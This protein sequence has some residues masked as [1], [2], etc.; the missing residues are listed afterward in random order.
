MPPV[1]RYGVTVALQILVLSVEVR[2]LLSQRD[3][4]KLLIDSNLEGF[5]DTNGTRSGH[6]LFS[7]YDTIMGLCKEKKMHFFKP[8][9]YIH[10][11]PAKLHATGEVWYISYYATNPE[12]GKL[13]RFRIKI[14]HINPIKER[15]K[16]AKEIISNLNEK[17]SLG[18]NP[19]LEQSS[20]H[21]GIKAF[22]AMDAFLKAK[23]K[24][25][26]DSTMR[27]YRSLVKIMKEWLLKN[28]FDK[29]SYANAF[30]KIVAIRFMDNTD[31]D[32]KLCAQ[33]YN[34]R[35]R[36]Y[37]IMCNWMV[38][39][40]YISSNPFASLKKKPKKLT[41]KTRRTFNPEELNRLWC[42]LEN[43]NQGFLLVCLFCYCC[44]M[45]PKEIVLL[46]CGDIDLNRQIISVRGEIAKNDNDS[47]RTIPDTMMKYLSKVDL[48]HK[49]WYLFSGSKYEFVPGAT[50]IWS[51]RISDYWFEKVRPACG[52]GND[53]QFYSLKDTGITN[54]LGQGIPASFVKQQADHSS[55]AM[56]SVYLGKSAKANEELK[57]VDIILNNSK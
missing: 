49:E 31:E 1:L 47:Q 7:L 52:F 42:F 56:T 46:K 3:P 30:S 25:S 23:E 39:K 43:N 14:N 29:N 33:T 12:T 18:W 45:R 4:S 38:E 35:L 21:G 34:N 40:G 16:A 19:M 54:M 10:Y 48:S 28:G 6:E 37:S 53:L 57:K 51:Q 15:K 26:E 13:K 22:D 32:R 8:T 41:H 9:A 27:T 44:L 50:K 20:H 11:V 17:L 24:E 36:F 5:N 2:I 55:L